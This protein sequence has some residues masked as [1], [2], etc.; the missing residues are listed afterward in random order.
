M[1]ILFYLLAIFGLQFLVTQSDGPFGIIGKARNLLMRAGV[2]G[3]FFYKLFSC[4]F[5]S[6]CYSGLIIYLIS[7]HSYKLSEGALWVLTGGSTCLILD[8]VLARLHRE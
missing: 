7:Q 8:G 3:P 5:C 1:N 6:G 2:L 4:P